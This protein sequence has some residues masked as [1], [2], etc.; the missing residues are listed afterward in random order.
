M[1][2]GVGSTQRRRQKMAE[3]TR[4]HKKVVRKN[5]K[6]PTETRKFDKGKVDL[7]D[8]GEAVIGRF[9]LQPGW[10]WSESVKPLVGTDWCEHTHVAYV[11]SGRLKTRLQDGSEDEA[12]PGDAV[13]TPSGHDAWVV[14]S[15]PVV[16]LDFRGAATY[17]KK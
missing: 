4:T 16:M 17:A 7:A 13:F 2:D 14:G 11:I 6:S 12:G 1:A 3:A 9:E 10:R 8:V 15:E 5:L